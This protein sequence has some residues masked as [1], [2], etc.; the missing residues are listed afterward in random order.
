MS[1][2]VP[3]LYIRF[4][5]VCPV[6]IR[7]RRKNLPYFNSTLMLKVSAPQLEEGQALALLGNQPA[8]GEW[9]PNFA[10]RMKETGL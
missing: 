7:P 8:L 9:N 3:P 2:L 4:Y 1:P 5:A 10:F 6:R